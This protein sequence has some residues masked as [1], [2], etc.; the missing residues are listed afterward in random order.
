MAWFL[1]MLSPS[2]P[3][4]A[5]YLSFLKQT[6]FLGGIENESFLECLAAG[7]EELTFDAKDVILRSGD[8]KQ[9]IFFIIEGQV[10]IHIDDIK[11]AELFQGAYF[12]DINIFNN[13]PTSA[14]ATTL[15]PTRCLV[16]RQSHLQATLQKYS[17]SKTEL[18]TRLY[19]RQ[20][21]IQPRTWQKS[22]VSGWCAQFQSPS[23]VY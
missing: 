1:D 10:K 2:S 23:W 16:L 14:S 5:N 21:T 15:K 17:N 20:K 7:L 11:I 4:L 12:G 9:L 8:Q 19:Q 18:I 13:Q 22:V 6:D 3:M